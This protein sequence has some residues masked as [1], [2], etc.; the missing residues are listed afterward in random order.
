MKFLATIILVVVVCI[1]SV[2]YI[3]VRGSLP[4]LDGTFSVSHLTTPVSV[5]RD[6][7]GVPT[8]RGTTRIDV[9]RAT[10]FVHGQDRFFQMDLMLSLIHI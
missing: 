1:V 8:I 9:A 7:L 3:A 10:G 4:I 6:A 2:T 5:E